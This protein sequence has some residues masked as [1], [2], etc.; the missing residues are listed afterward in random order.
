L[1]DIWIDGRLQV[2]ARIGEGEEIIS[3]TRLSHSLT[4]VNSG[5]LKFGNYFPNDWAGESALLQNKDV[6]KSPT[7]EFYFCYS[8]GGANGGP[9][10]VIPDDRE[11]ALGKS[12]GL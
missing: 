9:M 3:A 2:W 7:G 10:Q 4:A 6:Y 11:R 12:V 8:L 5:L 1:L